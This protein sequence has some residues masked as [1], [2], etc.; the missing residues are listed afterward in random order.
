MKFLKRSCLSRSRSRIKRERGSLSFADAQAQPFC[1]DEAACHGTRRQRR[2]AGLP[3]PSALR[4]ASQKNSIRE[5]TPHPTEPNW[6]L[7]K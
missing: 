4:S 2:H 1:T 3:G 6:T 5:S 7:T